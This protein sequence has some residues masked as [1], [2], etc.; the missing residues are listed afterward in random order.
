MQPPSLRSSTVRRLSIEHIFESG[1]L[2][3][4]PDTAVQ[5]SPE[6]LHHAGSKTPPRGDS[7]HRT[8]M[9]RPCQLQRWVFAVDR[10]AEFHPSGRHRQRA[11]FVVFVQS[12]FN[13]SAKSN[14]GAGP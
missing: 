7:D 14:N 6:R 5:L 2:I 8:A 4:K 12:S 1:G 13:V 3:G 9:F 10:P 11:D